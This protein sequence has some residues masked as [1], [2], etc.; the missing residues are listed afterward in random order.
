MSVKERIKEFIE[1]KKISQRSFEQ[2]SGLSN[3]YVNNISNSISHKKIEGISKAF[4]ELNISWLLLGEGEMIKNDGI[5]PS[6]DPD[7]EELEHLQIFKRVFEYIIKQVPKEPI[8][9]PFKMYADIL[10]FLGEVYGLN[11]S[12]KDRRLAFVNLWIK[13][14]PNMNKE[15]LMHGTGNPTNLIHQGSTAIAVGTKELTDDDDGEFDIIKRED[16]TEFRH[17][18]DERYLM[19]TPLVEQFAY[20]GYVSGWADTEY[21]DELPKHAIVVEKLHFGTY[22][23]FVARGDSMDNGMKG[24]IANGDIV[25]GRKLESKYWKHKLHLHKFQDYVIHCTD[26]IIIKRIISHD[27]ESGDITYESLNPD[28]EAYPLTTINLGNVVELY[29]IVAVTEK[30]G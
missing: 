10:P 18:G 28:K 27:P 4:P 22:R 11:T 21:V 24:S 3:G 1:Y 19:V 30:R 12:R 8:S 14:F 20:A 2:E 29:N 9:N 25:T 6:D 26:G 13:Q 15:W 23:S 17:L 5:V 16:G 7:F